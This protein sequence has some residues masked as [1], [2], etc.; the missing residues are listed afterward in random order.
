[1]TSIEMQQQTGTLNL[2]QRGWMGINK[3]EAKEKFQSI[4]NLSLMYSSMQASKPMTLK[5]EICKAFN[6]P[7]EVIFTRTR[8]REI[9]NARQ[10]YIFLMMTTNIK[11]K[12]VCFDILHV[13]GI[14]YRRPIKNMDNRDR[15][16]YMSRHTKLDHSTMYHSCQITQN[17]YETEPF[18]QNLIDRLRNDLFAGIIFM[19]NVK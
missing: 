9:V 8:K 15:P 19:P 1:M 4:K 6:I 18:Y 17:Y 16:G 2:E 11:D 10:V 5:A 14:R 12:V 7:E 3:E 13:K